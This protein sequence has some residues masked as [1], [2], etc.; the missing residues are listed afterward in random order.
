MRKRSV[1]ARGG[2]GLFLGLSLLVSTAEA[3]ITR[4]EI[5][6]RAM[7]ARGMSFGDTGAYE[8]LRGKMFGE[9]D[10]ADPLN[11]VIVDLDKAPR[12]AQGMVEYATDFLILKP[13]DM[14]MG[15]GKIFY[16]INNRGNTGALGALNDATTGGNDPTTAEDA[17]NGFLMRQGYAIVDAGWEGDVLPGNN[18]LTAQYPVVTDGGVEI[19]GTIAVQYDVSRHIPVTAVFRGIREGSPIGRRPA[20]LLRRLLGGWGEEASGARPAR[21]QAP[22]DTGGGDEHANERNG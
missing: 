6:S 12:N 3:R 7:F 20:S 11:A 2:T 17:G 10:P 21:L 15:N 16:G 4:I 9:V 13:V 18:R 5:T 14:S 22:A 19:T 1:W 8:K